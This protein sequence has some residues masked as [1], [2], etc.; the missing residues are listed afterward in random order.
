M[1]V[2]YEIYNLKRD[3]FGQTRYQISYEVE[4]RTSEGKIQIPFL[5]KLRRKQGEK[6]GF[7]FDQT[8]TKETENDYFE[9]DLAEAKP[10]RY[11]LK[12]KVK[13]L[14]TLQTTSQ[15][16]QFSIARTGR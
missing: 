3:T 1:F 16:S 15:T 13:D 2:Y 7:E 6:I 12:M 11:E 9:L 14:E 10:G 8:G 5:A 4:T